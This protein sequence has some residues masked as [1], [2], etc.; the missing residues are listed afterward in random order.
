VDIEGSSR[1]IRL[2]I[3]I[4][5]Q[6]D[7][8]NFPPVGALRVGIKHPDVKDAMLLIVFGEGGNV[9][10]Y[11]SDVLHCDDPSLLEGPR[12]LRHRARRETSTF[13][14]ARHLQRLSRLIM[15]FARQRNDV[16][17]TAKRRFVLGASK[18][19][20][21][22]LPVIVTTN[23]QDTLCRFSPRGKRQWPKIKSR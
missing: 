6:Q 13:V 8:G 14:I 18:L 19:G 11:I 7:H 20:A 10:S 3:R 9:W 22:A 17:V 1:A 21:G 2:S 15:C 12:G 5:V 16:T 23:S 4:D